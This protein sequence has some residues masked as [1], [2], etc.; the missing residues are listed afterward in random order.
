M[1]LEPGADFGR[2]RIEALL[3]EGGMGTVYKAYDRELD[4]IV[5]LKLLRPGLM[6]D[7][8]ALLR[9]KQELL[10]ASKISHKNIL[11]IHDLG[12]VNGIKFI[13]MALVEGEDLHSILKKHGDLPVDRLVGIARQL[14]AALAAAHA[15]GVVHRDLKPQNVLMDREGNAYV[16]DFGLAK[17][18]ES[19]AAGMT[20]TGEFIGTPRYM[21][22]EQV[23]GGN[24]D[25]R[26]DLYALGL[27]LY[28]MATGNIPFTGDSTLHLMFQRVKEKPKSPKLLNPELPD[29]LVRIIL[30]CLEKDPNHRYQSASEIQNDL[31]AERAPAA[32]RSVRITLPVPVSRNWLLLGGAM[33]LLLGSL[34]VPRVRNLVF[35]RGPGSATA[36][37]GAKLR[38]IAVL[39]FR[40]LGDSSSF[41]YLAEGL[42]ETLS[43]KL[44][45]LSDLRV[46]SGTAVE[47]ARASDS[48]EKTARDLGVTLV[49][50]GTVQ[51]MGDK[52][53]IVVNLE[54]IAGNKRL[55]SGEFSGLK[56]DLLTLEDQMYGQL[57]S[58]LELKPTSAELA[59]LSARPTESIAAYDLYLRGR[60][61]MR[62]QRGVKRTEAAMR[63][64]EEALK[65]DPNFALAYAGLAD[66]C[67]WMY[68]EKREDFW[69]ARALGAAQQAQRLNNDLPEVYF[70]LG[71][72]YSATGKT[73]GAIAEIRRALDLGPSSD[74]GYRRLGAAYLAD[75]RGPAAV[76][77]YL[78]AAEINPYYWFNHS[79][80]GAAYLRLGENEKA[81]A[82]FRRVTEIE[83]DNPLGHENI[84]LAY[85]RQGKWAEAVPAFEKALEL[86]PY[87]S[88]YSNLGTAYF[89]LKR[90]ADAVKMFEKAV[91]L[92]PNEEIAVGNLADAYR[93]SG[94]L[95]KA[96]ATYDRAIALAYK[97][98]QVNPKKAGTVGSLALYYAKKGDGKQA[99]QFIRRARL[100]NPAEVNLVYIEAVVQALAGQ[101]EGAL[102]SL[103]EAFERGYPPGEARNDP[104]LNSLHT[105]TEFESLIR[106]FSGKSG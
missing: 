70:S 57:V 48:L 46:A 9:F 35:H 49:V 68:Q 32:S 45:E 93:W 30:R 99:L 72:I 36:V 25:Q 75:G 88:T 1:R 6:A 14:A 81:L 92:N 69:V 63:F 76:Q 38:Y 24:L 73:A 5:A 53:R 105:R 44:F 101:P 84:G 61:A 50:H 51:G 96:R 33:L 66:A 74:E 28:E 83:P 82:S 52:I 13:S 8:V 20:R 90:Y 40:A 42:G 64:Y 22:P 27:I 98:L 54:D 60:E 37:P 100:M 26:S 94:Q 91:E 2:Y 3:G 39:P 77:A 15:E 67:L 10:L 80:L 95:E 59:R 79:T 7:P 102:K 87:Y 55:W 86:Q 31:E 19:G 16:S 18:L 78:K 97:E 29:Y 4:R 12:D 106:R 21:S 62:G 104:E 56:Q 47:K 71:S 65:N 85:V 23:E 17:S 34:A 89:Y 41:G 11:R 58:A 103:R 43:A